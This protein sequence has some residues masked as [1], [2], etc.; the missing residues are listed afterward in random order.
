[1][2]SLYRAFHLLEDI[3]LVYYTS[4]NNNLLLNWHE[5]KA[6]ALH[7]TVGV[8]GYDDQLEL[9]AKINEVTKLS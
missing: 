2:F 5:N 8:V 9:S 6:V 1:M 7:S 4:P 3:P